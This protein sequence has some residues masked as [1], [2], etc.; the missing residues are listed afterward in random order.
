MLSF[1]FRLLIDMNFYKNIT[2]RKAARH[3]TASPNHK[4]IYVFNTATYSSKA[5][6]PDLSIN[7]TKAS[8]NQ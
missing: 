5:F 4:S 7:L 6:L 3:Q 8:V 2:N 1:Y